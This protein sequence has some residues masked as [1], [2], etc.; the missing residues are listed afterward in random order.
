M[1]QSLV[2]KFKQAMSADEEQQSSSLLKQV[3]AAVTLSWKQSI[4]MLWTLN[5]TGFAIFYSL[6]SLVSICSSTVFLMGP[7]KQCQRMFEQHRVLATSVFLIAI[8]LTLFLAFKFGN[9]G[10]CLIMILI[11]LAALLW[12]ILQAHIS[13]RSV[14]AKPTQQ[15]KAAQK[16]EVDGYRYA[17]GAKSASTGRGGYNR[18]GGSQGGRDREYSRGP[19]WDEGGREGDEEGGEEAAMGGGSAGQRDAD[20][21]ARILGADTAFATAKAAATACT[22]HLTAPPVPHVGSLCLLPQEQEISTLI[23]KAPGWRS[24]DQLVQ[25]RGTELDAE[26]FSNIIYKVASEAAPTAPDDLEEY[27][28]LLRA[29]LGWIVQLLPTFRPYQVMRTLDAMSY[30][31]LYNPDV[32]T[33]LLDKVKSQLGNLMP[34]DLCLLLTFCLK[35]QHAPDA[36]WFQEFYRLASRTVATWYAQDLSTALAAVTQLGS[37]PPTEWMDVA[38]QG[39]MKQAGYF[40]NRSQIAVAVALMQVCQASEWQP[41]QEVVDAL[42]TGRS[43]QMLSPPG[44]TLEELAK[45]VWATTAFT[46]RP[47]PAWFAALELAIVRKMNY[48]NPDTIAS[49]CSYLSEKLQHPCGPELQDRLQRYYTR[50]MYDTSADNLARILYMLAY[51]S[52]KPSDKWLDDALIYMKTVIRTCTAEGLVLVYNA[53]PLLGSGRRLSDVGELYAEKVP[54]EEVSM[55]ESE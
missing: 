7:V 40:T 25:A 48:G 37:C 1:A 24:L 22:R 51:S 26:N 28:A 32:V 19:R 21:R 31:Q 13:W 33:G 52:F 8:V 29:L 11:Q 27:N 49:L 15:C 23:I 18:A 17:G 2:D 9:A 6:G 54:P 20:P 5:I 30:I 44:Y 4:P 50:V 39:I 10:L 3:D 36:D 38:A 35:L 47:G 45:L 55:T 16:E 43:Q 34:A 53:L 42:I 14:P 41:S 12:T 46:A